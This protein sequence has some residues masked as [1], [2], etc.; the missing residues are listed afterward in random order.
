MGRRVMRVRGGCGEESD[1][2]GGCGEDSD[3][4]G[5]WVWGGE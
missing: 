2:G 3:E 1:V 4:R 5:R